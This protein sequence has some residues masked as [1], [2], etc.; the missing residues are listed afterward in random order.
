MAAGQMA[1]TIALA[2]LGGIVIGVVVALVGNFLGL[3]IAVMG[4]VAGALTS[5]VFVALRQRQ[6]QGE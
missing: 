1:K 5:F 6:R 3:P 2:V 4:G